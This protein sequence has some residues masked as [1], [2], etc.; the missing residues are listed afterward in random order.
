MT[1]KAVGDKTEIFCRQA[2]AGTATA[3]ISASAR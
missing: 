1:F 2:V 3:P